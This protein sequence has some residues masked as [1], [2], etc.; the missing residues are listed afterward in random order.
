MHKPYW[1]L[2]TVTKKG[3]KSGEILRWAVYGWYSVPLDDPK[4]PL[5]TYSV[6]GWRGSRKHPFGRAFPDLYASD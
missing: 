6:Y 5:R 4:E 3:K 2:S 1:G